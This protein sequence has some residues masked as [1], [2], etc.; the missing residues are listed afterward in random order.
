MSVILIIFFVL[1][2]HNHTLL[3]SSRSAGSTMPIA[4]WEKKRWNNTVDIVNVYT[5]PWKYFKH[6]NQFVC[7]HS[8]PVGQLSFWDFIS[9]FFQ[10]TRDWHIR[11]IVGSVPQCGPMLPTNIFKHMLF[12]DEHL[13]KTP[14][15][16]DLNT[17]FKICICQLVEII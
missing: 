13:Y 9:R 11:H 7:R 15:N 14:M 3:P 12:I 10:N 4:S 8:Q 16:Y 2:I 17:K 5:S 6:D 1:I